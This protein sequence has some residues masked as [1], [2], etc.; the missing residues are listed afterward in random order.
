M[1]EIIDMCKRHTFYMLTKQPQ[2]IMA[3]LYEVTEAWPC[4]ELGGGDVIPNL[5]IG[6]S[7]DTQAR[8]EAA[9]DS[10]C[11][12]MSG[13]WHTF[14]SLEPLLGAIDRQWL[15]WEEWRIIGAMGGVGAAKH[16]PKREWVDD[17]VASADDAD[18]S[19]FLKSSIT[20]LWPDLTRRERPQDGVAEGAGNDDTE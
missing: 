11:N 3:K 20:A 2:N 9:W 1:L 16:Q 10:M 4:R 8:A 5:W 14:V 17:L 7:V 13:G 15:G 6:A 12:L 18:I 19:V